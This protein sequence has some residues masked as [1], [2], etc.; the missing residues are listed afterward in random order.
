MKIGS[1]D[2]N[3]LRGL[4][5]KFVGVGKEVLGTVIGN[6]RLQDEGQAQQ[7]KATE[8]LKAFREQAKAEKHEAKAEALEQ[9]QKAAQRAKQNA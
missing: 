3:N 5:D 8:N 2:L 6:E 4:T 9:K 1:I 7:D